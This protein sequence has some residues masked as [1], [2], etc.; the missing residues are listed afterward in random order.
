[1][2]RMFRIDRPRAGRARERGAASTPT[3]SP[4]ARPLARERGQSLIEVALSL[5]L[6]LLIVI[7][8]ADFGRAYYYSIALTNA[9]REGAAYAARTEGATSSGVAQVACDETGLVAYNAAC[10][11]AFQ[12]QY[13]APA[14]A[15]WDATYQVTVTYQLELI[16]SYLVNRIFQANPVT[17]RASASFPL[18]R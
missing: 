9:A 6:L 12:V 15:T 1:M 14:S 5:P 8:L 13:T 2:F 17:L 4:R 10:P 18:L 7:G 3:A 11:A 16:S